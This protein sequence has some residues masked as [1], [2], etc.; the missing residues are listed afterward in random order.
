LGGVKD[1]AGRDDFVGI[2]DVLAG[3]E[4][5]FARRSMPSIQYPTAKVSGVVQ[6]LA[7]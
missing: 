3:R 7:P 4:V 2:E 5:S 1:D 6:Q